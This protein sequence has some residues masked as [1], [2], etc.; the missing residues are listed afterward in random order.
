MHYTIAHMCTSSPPVVCHW[1]NPNSHSLWLTSHYR[2]CDHP[3]PFYVVVIFFGNI[4]RIQI[5]ES[6]G[7]SNLVTFVFPFEHHVYWSL[8]WF[9]WFVL[10]PT[11]YKSYFSSMPSPVCIY[12]LVTRSEMRLHFVGDLICS[13][14]QVNQENGD[15]TCNWFRSTRKIS[16]MTTG[17]HICF[18]L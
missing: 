10:P 17:P 3:P 16:L 13:S 8:S 18:C 7:R 2:S 6:C 11:V 14:A 5:P 15:F 9:Y 4:P 1:A 12:L